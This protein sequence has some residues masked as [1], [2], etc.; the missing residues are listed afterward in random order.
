MSVFIC[1][2]GTRSETI[3][4]AVKVLLTSE[5]KLGLKKDDVFI[6]GG[7]EKG[8]TWFQSIVE[9]LK[10]ST[11]RRVMKWLERGG[12]ARQKCRKTAPPAAQD[13]LGARPAKSA[14]LL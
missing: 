3:A 11:S 5:K 8:T 14:S 1:W 9:E 7:I 12:S 13:R 4:K 2:S 6:S 10:K